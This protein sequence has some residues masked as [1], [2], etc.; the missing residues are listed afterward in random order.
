MEQVE[1]AQGEKGVVP[2]IVIVDHGSRNAGANAVVEDL[3]RQ[4]QHRAGARASVHFA[5]MELG[6]PSLPAAIEACVAAGAQVVVVQPLFLAPGKH[7]ARDIPELVADARRR[8]PE[9]E[10]R[11]GG[12]IGADPLLADMLWERSRSI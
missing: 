8:H 4:V 10:F 11:L 2:A 6:E 3:A 12:V 1:Q 5:H 9:V 7:A